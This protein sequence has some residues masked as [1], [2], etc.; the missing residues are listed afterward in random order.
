MDSYNIILIKEKV[1]TFWEHFSHKQETMKLGFDQLCSAIGRL[2]ADVKE[3]LS[4]RKVDAIS[5]VRHISNTHRT[6]YG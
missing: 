1:P 3:V 2:Y 5:R 4:P 6:I